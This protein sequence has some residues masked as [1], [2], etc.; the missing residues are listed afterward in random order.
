M[1]EKLQQLIEERERKD[2]FQSR[3]GSSFFWFILFGLG[4]MAAHSLIEILYGTGHSHPIWSDTFNWFPLI[5]QV[6]AIS[7]LSSLIYAN[8]NTWIQ[9]SSALK[10]RF[11]F[12]FKKPLFNFNSAFKIRSPIRAKQWLRRMAQIVEKNAQTVSRFMTRS[13]QPDVY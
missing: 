6:A 5:L 1:E 8:A 11:S 10:Q 2:N 3:L 7:F 12:D 13:T 9:S 4:F